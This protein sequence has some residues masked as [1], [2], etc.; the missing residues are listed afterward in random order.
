M[1]VTRYSNNYLIAAGKARST[2]FAIP[3]LRAA[4]SLGRVKVKEHTLRESMRLDQLAGKFLG[5]AK[6]WWMI[7][8]LSDIGWSL[9]V[10]PGT[11]IVIPV[12]IEQVRRN[13]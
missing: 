4:V 7:A 8:A 9:Q 3:A 12:D 5:D 1:R 2:S 13:I 10:P 6:H 11:R